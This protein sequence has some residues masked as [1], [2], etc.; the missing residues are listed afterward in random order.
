[1][2]VRRVV[3]RGWRMIRASAAVLYSPNHMYD[4][5]R[6]CLAELDDSASSYRIPI[7]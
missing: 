2:Q 7:A 3:A 5:V 1:M 6:Y 4:S